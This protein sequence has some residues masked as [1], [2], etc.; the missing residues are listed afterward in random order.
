MGCG[1]PTVVLRVF[2]SRSF[3]SAIPDATIG[4]EALVPA[5]NKRGVVPE[6]DEYPPTGDLTGSTHLRKRRET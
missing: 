2:M 6:L 4:A 3:K 1:Q 5:A